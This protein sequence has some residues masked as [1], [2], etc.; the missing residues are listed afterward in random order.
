MVTE[1]NLLDLF[2]ASLKQVSTI[3]ALNKLKAN[4][5]GKHG[6]IT[7]LL[8]LIKENNAEGFNIFMNNFEVA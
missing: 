5:L 8:K 4:Y 3:D 7:E 2:Y 1:P 6:Q